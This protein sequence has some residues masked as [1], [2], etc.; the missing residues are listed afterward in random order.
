MSDKEVKIVL[1]KEL[2]C[3]DF[4]TCLFPY[5][6]QTKYFVGEHVSGQ[7]VLELP[8]D[9]KHKGYLPTGFSLSPPA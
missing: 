2:V 5:C 9:E 4:I 3:T 6:L 8:K 1:P 7:L